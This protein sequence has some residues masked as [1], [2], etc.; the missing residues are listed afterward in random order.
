[1]ELEKLKQ[2]DNELRNLSK[3]YLSMIA[4]GSI[5][6]GDFYLKG[7]SDIDI[8]LLLMDNFS[9]EMS[10]IKKLI[11]RFNFDKNYFFTLIPKNQFGRPNSKYSFSN[12]FRSK[13]LFGKDFVAEAKLPN[14]EE[15]KLIYTKEL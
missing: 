5:V 3:N 7:G 6:T 8:V 11:E 14:K 13:T 10:Q 12:K 15:I 1:M 9:D 2:F 4:V